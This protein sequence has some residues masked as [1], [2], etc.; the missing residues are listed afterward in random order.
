MFIPQLQMNTPTRASSSSTAFSN[1]NSFLVMSF[2]LS[3]A[4][5]PA[6]FAAAPLACA[7]L[8]GMSFGEERAPQT[9]IPGLE[10]SSGENNL[11]EQNPYLFKLI[12]SFWANSPMWLGGSIPTASTTRLNSSSFGSPSSTYLNRRFW[13]FGNC[14][15]LEILLLMNLIPCSSF[16]LW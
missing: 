4:M 9:Y 7:T 11:V 16:A 5:I 6:A 14:S 13:N 1:G 10:L 12:P 8:S 15:I 2:P 3:E